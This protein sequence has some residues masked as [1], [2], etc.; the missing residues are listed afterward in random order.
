MEV[1]AAL[2]A[3]RCSPASMRQEHLLPT[4]HTLTSALRSCQTLGGDE[5]VSH[6]S[7]L[8]P[9]QYSISHSTMHGPIIGPTIAICHGRRSRSASR[10]R[11][12]NQP[13]NTSQLLYVLQ[14]PRCAAPG[15]RSTAACWCAPPTP[16]CRV[17][18]SDRTGTSRRGPH[19]PLCMPH[20][21]VDVP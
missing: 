21:V 8:S 5:V 6:G 11:N 13:T 3:R 18:S 7:T 10:V 14:Q 9:H 20:I 1:P 15:A 16:R 4:P 12:A 19:D 2:I 17:R